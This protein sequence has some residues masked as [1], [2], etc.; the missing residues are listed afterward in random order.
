VNL[1]NWLD[2]LLPQLPHYGFALVFLMVFLSNIGA[3]F[4]GKVMLSGAGFVWARTAGSLW[5][6]MLAGTLAAFLGGFCAFWLGRRLGHE[7]LERIHWLH[8]TQARFEWPERLFK[9]HGDKT[10]FLARFFP[11]GPR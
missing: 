11:K 5:E 2:R 3:P 9:R 4:P 7:R 8:L 1:L 6:P 10:V